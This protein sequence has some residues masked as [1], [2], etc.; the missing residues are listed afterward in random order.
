MKELQKLEQKCTYDTDNKKWKVPLF[1]IG[2]KQVSFPKLKLN[3]GIGYGT[4]SVDK[5][6]A[7]IP[8]FRIKSKHCFLRIKS[9]TERLGSKTCTKM[10]P[11]N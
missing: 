8:E 3:H 4:T 5:K 10:I 6:K 7:V 1:T 2:Q 9:E 11:T